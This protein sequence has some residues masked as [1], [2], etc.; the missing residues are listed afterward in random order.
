MKINLVKCPFPEVQ[1]CENCVYL[2]EIKESPCNDIRAV[3][4][5]DIPSLKET[6]DNE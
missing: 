5:C 3:C 2:V 1:T 6:I 4:A